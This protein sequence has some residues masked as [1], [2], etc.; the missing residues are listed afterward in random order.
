MS[1]ETCESI[2]NVRRKLQRIGSNH[3]IFLDE[4][5]K[6]V[7]EVD[8]YTIV[9]PG[10]PSTIRT[11]TSSNKSE[12]YDMI[13]AIT[14]KTTL[15]PTIYDSTERGKG[16]TT[17]MLLNYIRDV[18][19]QACGALDIYPMILVLD[20]A[21]IHVP[22]KIME[23]FHEWGCQSL[24]EVIKLPPSTAKRVSPLD[25]ALFNIW[26]TKVLKHGFL[27]K[28]SIRTKMSDAWNQITEKQIHEQYKK[29]GIIRGTNV[30]YDCP[31]PT[32]HRHS[33]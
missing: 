26:K 11:S 32:A 8:N 9:L 12:R 3:I 31:N 22:N 18:L 19:A 21:S 20:H 2:A 16:L 25:N 27:T 23:V 7:G 5:L 10:E 1:A 15:P 4:T 30:Y 17:K 29:S 33:S 14:G 28:Q 6:R 13:G 24:T